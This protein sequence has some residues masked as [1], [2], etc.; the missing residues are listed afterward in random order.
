MKCR[1]CIELFSDYIEGTLSKDLMNE[2]KSHISR[3]ERCRILLHTYSLTIRLSKKGETFYRVSPL[4]MD[5]LKSLL[6][7]RLGI[8]K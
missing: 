1:H 8:E 6:N 4:M 3:C 7:T 5:R 2:V